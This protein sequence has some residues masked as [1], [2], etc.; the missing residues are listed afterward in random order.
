MVRAYASRG[1]PGI[2]T[3]VIRSLPSPRLAWLVQMPREFDFE[4]AAWPKRF[5]YTGPWH[6]GS[7]R[8]DTNFPWDRLTGDPLIYASMGTL[9]NGQDDGIQHDFRSSGE[10]PWIAIGAFH[11]SESTSRAHSVC[12]GQRDCG[13]TSTAARTAQAFRLVHYTRRSKHYARILGARSADGGPSGCTTI[14]S[15]WRRGL[16]RPGQASSL[17]CQA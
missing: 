3:G 8:M 6:D 11:R 15:A 5:H 10:S 17:T 9:M 16:H 4:A 2:S 1:W 13:A 7:G 14:S 12:A